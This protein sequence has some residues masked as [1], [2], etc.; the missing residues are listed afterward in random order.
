[1]ALVLGAGLALSI[2]EFALGWLRLPEGD[3]R[4]R[5]GWLLAGISVA[6]LGAADYLPSFGVEVPPVGSIFALAGLGLIAVAV[7]RYRLGDLTPGYAAETILATIPDPV[8]VCDREGRIAIVN[9]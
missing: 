5:V 7:V 9:R 3:E 4:R 6:S 1:M 8:I 2:G